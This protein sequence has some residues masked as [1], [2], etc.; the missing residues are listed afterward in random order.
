[1]GLDL[2]IISN[3]EF[4]EDLG[5]VKDK[6]LDKLDFAYNDPYLR[7]YFKSATR[8]DSFKEWNTNSWEFDLMGLKSLKH[9]I[10]V[11]NCVCFNGPWAIS[12]RLGLKSYQL[13][14]NLRWY[15]FLENE[16]LQNRIFALMIMMNQVFRSEYNIY[17]PDNGTQ[18]SGYSDLVTENFNL[19]EI[20]TKLKNEIGKPCKS[21]DELV[22]QFEINEN[23][24]LKK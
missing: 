9:V 13:D 8:A 10:H 15:H 1:M 21:I 6:V 19:D 4:H 20:L 16:V 17:I 11:D 12:M 2:T 14:L 5:S 18:S 24:Y 22:S 7:D 23:A 3:H